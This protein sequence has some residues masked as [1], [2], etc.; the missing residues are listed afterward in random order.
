SRSGFMPLDSTITAELPCSFGFSRR[1]RSFSS[2][3]PKMSRDA[4]KPMK[5]TAP[6]MQPMRISWSFILH[7]H[8]RDLSDRP[9]SEHLQSEGEAEHFFSGG[10]AG[11]VVGVRGVHEGDQEKHHRGKGHQDVTGKSA[12]GGLGLDMT[13]EPQAL[14]DHAADVLEDFR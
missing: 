8:S 9:E 14:A 4:K 12:F 13:L 1:E 7:L 5:T 3:L 2:L 10:R 11:E 6:K